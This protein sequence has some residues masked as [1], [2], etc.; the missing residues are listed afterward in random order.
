[1]DMR[2]E[3]DRSDQKLKLEKAMGE[4]R[5]KTGASKARSSNGNGSAASTAKDALDS[6]V[7][8]ESET[9]DVAMSALDAVGKLGEGFERLANIMGAPKRAVYDNAGRIVGSE[10]ITP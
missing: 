2:C 9:A 6:L 1:M 8:R 7:E 4:M 5:V 3:Q 10:V